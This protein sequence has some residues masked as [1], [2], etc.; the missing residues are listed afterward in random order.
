[1][2]EWLKVK[3]LSLSPNTAKKKKKKKKKRN[4]QIWGCACSSLVESL[5]TMYKALGSSQ[6][7]NRQKVFK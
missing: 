5:L 3:A 2:V 6:P 1:M 4:R 7:T